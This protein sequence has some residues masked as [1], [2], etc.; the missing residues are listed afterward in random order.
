MNSRASH[1][2]ASATSHAGAPTTVGRRA[3]DDEALRQT[4]AGHDGDMRRSVGAGPAIAPLGQHAPLATPRDAATPT[5]QRA[6]VPGIRVDADR[7]SQRVRGQQTLR[8]I[9]LAIAPGELVAI[10]GSS[11]A[12]KTMLLETLAGLRRPET[13]MVR[14]DGTDCQASLSDLR[15]SLG[16][17]P[18]DDIIHPELSLGRTLW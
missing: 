18:Q 11:G 6:A 14:Y 13:G 10:V 1:Q 5:T 12:G 15:S 8:E 16:Y 3:A 4:S 7:V 2:R 17:V 9:S